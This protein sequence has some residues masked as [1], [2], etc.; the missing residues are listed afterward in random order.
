LKPTR[1]R[2]VVLRQIYWRLMPINCCVVQRG[3]NRMKDKEKEERRPRR[4]KVAKLEE[5]LREEREKSSEY[6]K[7]LK[8]LQ[9]DFEN[10]RK[11]MEKEA[12]EMARTSSD[13]L[14]NSLLPV[15]DELEF[16]LISGSKS[17]DKEAILEGVKITLRKM[18]N[19]LGE[20]G[21]TAIKAAGERFNPEMHEAVS[22][23]ATGDSEEGS[24]IEEVRRGFMLRGRVIRPS[25]VKIAAKEEEEG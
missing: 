5:E 12:V 23:V 10:Y 15:L 14:I 13:R 21:L 19:I 6:L 25:M 16:A 3:Q 1:M 8:Y 2:S 11:R 24:V 4:G 9:A 7:R 17:K 22:T 18:Y 20:Y